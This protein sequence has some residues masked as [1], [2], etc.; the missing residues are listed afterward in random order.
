[1][2]WFPMQM[3]YSIKHREKAKYESTL[4]PWAPR[5]MHAFWVKVRIFSTLHLYSHTVY[6]V[7][8]MICW[9]V[10]SNIPSLHCIFT[11]SAE[12]NTLLRHNS[13]APYLLSTTIPEQPFHIVTRC[14]LIQCLLV[15]SSALTKEWPMA[16][17][18]LIQ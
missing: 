12:A 13:S 10:D 17:T 15:L 16:C 18:L 3:I 9:R 11:K 1:M 8:Y 6:A 4:I 7:C 5:K 14:S 2:P